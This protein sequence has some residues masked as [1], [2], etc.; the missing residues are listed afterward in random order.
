MDLPPD[1]LKKYTTPGP[2]A[3]RTP[4]QEA[5]WRFLARL[6]QGK[7]RVRTKPMTYARLAKLLEGMSVAEIHTLYRDCEQGRSF[8]ALFWWKIKQ[9][10]DGTT[11]SRRHVLR[12]LDG[13][14]STT[15]ARELQ[16]K[17]LI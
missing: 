8:G 11:S 6:N 1:I 9:R 16:A 17:P 2:H 5:I 13:G 15:R 4:E 14:D 7:P 10:S 12:T 3:P